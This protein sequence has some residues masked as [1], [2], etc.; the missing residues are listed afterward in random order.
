M[1]AESAK[2]RFANSAIQNEA[3]AE[4]RAVAVNTEPP[5]I[6]AAPRIF[7]LTARI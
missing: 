4:A 1:P 3:R 5:S 6:P 7:G 2:G